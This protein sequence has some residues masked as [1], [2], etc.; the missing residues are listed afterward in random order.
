MAF[1]LG[2][3]GAGGAFRVGTL[4]ANT[5]PRVRSAM[6]WIEKQ[7]QMPRALCIQGTVLD[8]AAEAGAHQ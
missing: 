2:E 8:P 1:R 3:V 4:N 7:C 6:P 5:W